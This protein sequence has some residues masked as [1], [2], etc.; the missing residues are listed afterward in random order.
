MSYTFTWLK[1]LKTV[2]YPRYLEHAVML[3]AFDRSSFELSEIKSSD[4]CFII[5]TF[6]CLCVFLRDTM[7]KSSY[8]SAMVF[9]GFSDDFCLLGAL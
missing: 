8:E 5:L 2:S 6:Q 1:H 7:L 4:F 3:S 9:L